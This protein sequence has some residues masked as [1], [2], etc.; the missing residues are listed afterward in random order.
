[1]S[2]Y[3]KVSSA[4]GSCH[5]DATITAISAT[6]CITNSCDF[7]SGGIP[8]KHSNIGHTGMTGALTFLNNRVHD[9][10]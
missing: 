7:K 9:E 3:F 2:H 8:Q 4:T 1:M 10:L 5:I 6:M